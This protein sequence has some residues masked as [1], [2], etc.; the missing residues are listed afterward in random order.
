MSI[1]WRGTL[2]VADT[3]RQGYHRRLQ[4]FTSRKGYYMT[5]GLGFDY[6][7]IIPS[8]SEG[9]QQLALLYCHSPPGLYKELLVSIEG[10]F[11]PTTT[12]DH[13]WR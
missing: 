10:Y 5:P 13:V 9:C 8:A 3:E 4:M 12:L 1:L 2:R 11:P 6:Y 7:I